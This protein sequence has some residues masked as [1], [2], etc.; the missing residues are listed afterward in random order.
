MSS[1]MKKTKN[2]IGSFRRESD[3]GPIQIALTRQFEIQIPVFKKI[4]TIIQSLGNMPDF[5]NET[6]LV[7]WINKIHSNQEYIQLMHVEVT[8]DLQQMS[9]EAPSKRVVKINLQKK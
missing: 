1:D 8:G 9:A 2:L 4:E 6:E 5:S 3:D 7:I